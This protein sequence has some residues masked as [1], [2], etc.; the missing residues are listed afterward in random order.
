MAPVFH[1]TQFSELQ[2]A[3]SAHCSLAVLCT[4]P[5][6]GAALVL[7]GVFDQLWLLIYWCISLS[8]LLD[9]YQDSSLYQGQGARRVASAYGWVTIMILSMVKQSH[10]LIF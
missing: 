1:L 10:P 6:E 8:W 5:G 7:G 4:S 3:T 2:K 9:C